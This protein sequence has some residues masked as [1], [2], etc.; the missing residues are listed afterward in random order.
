MQR[1]FDGLERYTPDARVVE[2]LGLRPAR[3]EL[4]RAEH[5]VSAARYWE[6]G[7]TRSRLP[8]QQL[9]RPLP[10]AARRSH[11]RAVGLRREQP[12]VARHVAQLIGLPGKLGI[13]GADVWSAYQRGE[14]AAIRNYCETDVL[15]TYL[16]YLRFQLL[17]G[18]LDPKQHTRGEL[19]Q[20]EAKLE[21]SDR[22]HL[23]EYPR[24][25]ARRRAC[26][27]T[28]SQSPPRIVDLT[29]DGEGVADIDGRRVFV[30]DALPGERV[31]IVLRK[32]RRKLLEADARARA[33]AV[34]RPR[35]RPSASTSAAAAAARCS[36]SRTPRRSRSSKASSRRRSR[37][38]RAS[39]PRNG[40]RRSR[41]RR[42]ATGAARGSA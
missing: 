24:G 7:E 28:A 14:L 13:S 34:V 42:G 21:Q 15:N 16:I 11:G 25:L 10:L 8:L 37:A 29:H 5:G 33:R 27:L 17:R 23:R 30:P 1:F 20:V 32:R 39:S 18:E 12:R 3:A 35:A 40:C 36:T 22:P 41:A 9:S 2:R 31:E 38:S 19:Q 6:V 4:S 26:G